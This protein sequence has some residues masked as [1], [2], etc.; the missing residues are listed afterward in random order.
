MLNPRLEFVV[1][2]DGEL[3]GLYKRVE[4]PKCTK[5]HELRGQRDR[6]KKIECIRCGHVI[7]ISSE[8]AT[9]Y[10]DYGFDGKR[11]REKVGSDK[12]TAE[13]ALHKRL[14]SI[15]ENRYLDVKDKNDELFDDFIKEY[16]ELHSKQNNKSWKHSDRQNLKMLKN[17]FGGKHL[18]DITP[19]LIEKFRQQR[20][21][22]VKA[23]TVNRN[24]A[25]L[26]S[27]FN[28][29]RTWNR[30]SGDNPLTHVKKLKV[31][32]FRERFLEQ[33]EV[34]KLIDAC[35][36]YLKT[37]VIIA[38]NT[39]MRRGE[40]LSLKWSDID[41]DRSILYLLNTKNRKKREVPRRNAFLS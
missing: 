1:F 34:L 22:N 10:I 11:V 38:V 30:F 13:K 14:T 31:Q 12:E 9:Y 40:I 7:T 37:I 5:R 36:G 24:L 18:S 32:A 19:H 29:A 39:G 20:L 2:I 26:S 21:K 27:V 35:E 41:F 6:L 8:S 25:C 17:F 28:K 3:M 16:Y 23:S 15:A 4:C 33:C